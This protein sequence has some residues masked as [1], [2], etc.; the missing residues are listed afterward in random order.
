MEYVAAALIGFVAGVS[1]GMLGV[2]GGIIFVPGLVFA[3]GLSQLSA[4]AT[5]LLAIVPVALVGA[6]RQREYGNVRLRDGLVLGALSP[7]GVVAGA[8]LANVLSARALE[9]S[10][11]AVQLV[12]AFGLAR[13]ALRGS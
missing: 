6:W 5:S 7:V 9:L 3:L 2:G 8:E 11:A 1:S 10:F 13:R 12:F 4:E